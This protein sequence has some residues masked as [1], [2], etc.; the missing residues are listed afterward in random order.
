MNSVEGASLR[1]MG[2]RLKMA[3][4]SKPILFIGGKTQ[5]STVT[6]FSTGSSVHCP[7]K[8]YYDERRD[9][10]TFSALF[11]LLTTLPLSQ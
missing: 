11:L 4:E 3:T 9:K 6:S 2:T 10:S 7:Q 8:K 5:R 1:T